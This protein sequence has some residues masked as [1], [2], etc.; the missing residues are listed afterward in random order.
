MCIIFVFITAFVL[1]DKFRNMLLH[2]LEIAILLNSFNNI[3][4]TPIAVFD[5]IIILSNIIP[6]SLDGDL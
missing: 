4:N 2:P 3:Y 1:F 6:Y 5:K